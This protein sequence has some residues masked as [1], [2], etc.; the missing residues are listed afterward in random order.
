MGIT[1]NNTTE[2]IIVMKSGQEPTKLTLEQ[3]ADL[4]LKSLTMVMKDAFSFFTFVN[5]MN[6]K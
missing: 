1:Y 2:K 3:F 4:Y 5:S 6:Q